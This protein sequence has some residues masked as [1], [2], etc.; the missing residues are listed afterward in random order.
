MAFNFG[1]RSSGPS[2]GLGIV[3][4]T[5]F[6]AAMAGMFW[7]ESRTAH[8]ATAL[9]E[10]EKVA[11]SA[12]AAQALPANEGKAIALSDIATT[13]TGATDPVFPIGDSNTLKVSRR[14]EMYQ[15]DKHTSGTGSKRRTEWRQKWSSSEESGD[16]SHSNPEF[17]L[18]S[19]ST[20][21]NDA[22][23]GA[24]TIS[25]E[26]I[27]E[28]DGEPAQLPSELSVELHDQGWRANSSSGFFLGKGDPDR[29]EIGD[30]RVSFRVIEEGPISVIAKQ[31]N[32]AVVPYMAKNGEELFLIEPGK[33]TKETVIANAKSSNTSMAYIIRGVTALGMT[34]GLG[35]AFSG[36]VS[37]LSW[38]P[39]LGPLL[40]RFA[41]FTGA[42]TGFVLS[43]FVFVGAWL[44]AHP[45]M[46]I[47][48]V[49]AM[50]ALGFWL[51]QRKRQAA[52]H[53]SPAMQMPPMPPPPMQQVMSS[54][55]PPPPPGQ[56]PL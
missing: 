30:V 12:P 9:A 51:I 28:L 29:P 37:W 32:D 41:F 46:L 42:A 6:S 2:K 21:A 4:L 55:P 19:E 49:A 34:L 35:M 7:N 20:L 18:R 8:K 26:H 56:T 10:L 22:H 50:S 31:S 1:S 38:I 11:I 33:L 44:W 23:L 52:L 5:M 43:I 39:F 17:P 45:L 54:T 25:G 14:V 40:E 24:F 48:A 15:W 27:D 13:D 47:L 3:G 36:L 16:S 53:L